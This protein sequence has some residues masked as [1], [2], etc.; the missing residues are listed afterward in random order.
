MSS[1]APVTR[2]AATERALELLAEG[3]STAEETS[4]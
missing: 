4:A 3:V 2:L 1:A